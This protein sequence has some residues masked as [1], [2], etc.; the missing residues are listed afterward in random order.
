MQQYLT[1]TLAQEIYAISIGKVREIVEFHSLTRIPMMPDFLCGVTNLRG[2]VIPVI[3]L[4][5]RFGKGTTVI[6]NR[7]C[8]VIVEVE[9]AD[10]MT[11]L[12]VLVNSV[13]EVVPVQE[14]DIEPRP[15]FGS[16]IRAEFIDA[17]LNLHGEFVISLD[18]QQALSIQEMAG[19]AMN[20]G[21]GSSSQNGEVMP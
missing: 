9:H 20:W 17:L 7:S 8:I 21:S 14:Q 16:S 2:A 13:N 11:P 19:L 6:G 4:L 5:S 10:E 12:G 1:F 18:I 15:S 3:D